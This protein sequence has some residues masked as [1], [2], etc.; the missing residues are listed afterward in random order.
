MF[1]NPEIRAPKPSLAWPGPLV[2]PGAQTKQLF[3]K[4]GQ[5]QALGGW[6][7]LGGTVFLSLG[8]AKQRADPLDPLL[9]QAQGEATQH[10]P[11]GWSW[12]CQQCWTLWGHHRGDITPCSRHLLPSQRWGKQHLPACL[13]AC[14]QLDFAP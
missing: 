13:P 7:G 12:L 11:R 5:N 8:I 4:L 9:S 3:L 1:N 2:S 6:Q 14:S 10:Q